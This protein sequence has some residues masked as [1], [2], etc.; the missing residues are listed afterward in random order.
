MSDNFFDVVFEKNLQDI[1]TLQIKIYLDN[2]KRNC[3][4]LSDE[5]FV[6]SGINRIFSQ[7]KTGR[8]FLQKS[9]E[10]FNI[11]ISRSTFSDA[12]H[13]LRRL[14]LVRQVAS[15]NY[16]ALDQELISDEID[17]LNEFEE[18]KGYDVF[19]VD[20]H[21][22]EHSSHTGKNEK[23]KV[24]APGNLYALNMR[25]GLMQH[26]ACVSDGTVKNHE[27]PIFRN[28]MQIE[29]S[30]NNTK[31][32]TIWINDRAFLDY[33]WW[34]KQK[35]NGIYAISRLKTNSSILY[36]GDLK[37]DSDDPVNAGVISDRLG[38]ASSSGTT[39]R[40]ITY[41]DPETGEE[42]TF[43]TTLGK[44][45]R[46]GVVCWLYFLR[47][48]IEK[49]FDCFKNSFKEK[50]AWATGNKATEIQ[51]HFI[52]LVYNFVQ[53]LSEKT[54]KRESCEDEKAEKKY[55]K[56][57]KVREKKAK[58]L[59]RFIHPLIYIGRRISRISNQFIRVV[60][61]HFFLKIPL[62]LIIPIFVDRLKRY[63]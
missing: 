31:K 54:K 28:R 46:P 51:G 4:S 21:Y 24:Y 26:F 37:F 58:E 52:C 59:G 3:S 23:G 57:L 60:Q 16:G 22:I 44:E 14:D 43:Y 45:V 12:M 63:L 62:R 36:C 55:A 34:A 50:K 30:F 49:A 38:G 18:I 6:N 8:E 17:Y 35:K 32:K 48:K 27:M 5:L 2:I 47:W 53:F 11:K 39:M 42:M 25:N 41:I 61:N 9:D 13:S 1:F 19:S 20:G 56:N 29:N 33:R 10:M 40:I 15:L 7:C